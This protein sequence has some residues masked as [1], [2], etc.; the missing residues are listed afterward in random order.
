M[1]T[2]WHTG[3]GSLFL[4]DQMVLPAPWACSADWMQASVRGER[5]FWWETN[6]DTGEWM[7][8]WISPWPIWMMFPLSAPT[9][10]HSPWPL[11]SPHLIEWL[12]ILHGSCRNSAWASL[13]VVRHQMPCQTPI[14]RSHQDVLCHVRLIDFQFVKKTGVKGA[15][16]GGKCSVSRQVLKEGCQQE[17]D[18]S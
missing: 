6:W 7:L 15:N 11:L 9:W 2:S 5:K 10:F 17:T 3:P 16:E 4:S 13:T 1:P 12:H 14:T 8:P 18:S